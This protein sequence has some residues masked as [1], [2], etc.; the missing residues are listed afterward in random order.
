VLVNWASALAVTGAFVLIFSEYLEG[1]M[2][3]RYRRDRT[4]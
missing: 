3:A 4:S 1:N 2:V